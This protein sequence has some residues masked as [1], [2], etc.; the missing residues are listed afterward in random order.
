M[1][2]Y[3]ENKIKLCLVEFKSLRQSKE[4]TNSKQACESRR[5]PDS[6]EKKSTGGVCLIQQVEFS[7]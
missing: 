5:C 3:Q 4:S 1:V 6:V 7:L 2:Q